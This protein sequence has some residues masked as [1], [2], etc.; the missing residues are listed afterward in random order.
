V[1]VEQ[2]LVS[3]FLSSHPDDAARVLE[4]MPLDQAVAVLNEAPP[5][6]GARSLSGMGPE[7]ASRCLANL[8]PA[9]GCAMIE[10]LPAGAAAILLRRLAP[11]R[12]EALLRGIQAKTRERLELLLRYPEDTAGGIMDVLAATVPDDLSIEQVRQRLREFPAHLYYYVYVVGRDQALAG[13]VSLRELLVAGGDEPVRAVMK[14]NV[15]RVSDRVPL[16]AVLVHPGWRDFH[17]L[18]VVSEDGVFVGMIRYKTVR[19]LAEES[20]AGQGPAGMDTLF[21]LGELYWTGLVELFGGMSSGTRG[22]RRP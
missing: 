12:R 13:V 10:A 19:R 20:D 1:D 8:E 21:A 15:V 18:P 16:A 7:L 17:A 5:A 11:E 14:P 4:H 22:P 3:E 6:A 2:A 9:Q